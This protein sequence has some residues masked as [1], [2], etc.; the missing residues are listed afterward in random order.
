MF[1]VFLFQVDE[2]K[3]HWRSCQDQFLR[4]I[5]QQGRVRD[6]QKKA[7]SFHGPTD[8]PQAINKALSVSK[9]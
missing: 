5:Q 2:V 8:V 1:V 4:E 7:I 9:L 3:S 6:L